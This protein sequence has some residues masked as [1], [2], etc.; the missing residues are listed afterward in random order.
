MLIKE[1]RVILPMTVEEYQ[2]AQLYSVAEAS[3]NET[4]GGEGVKVEKN[5]PYDNVPLLNG[6]FTK[7]QYTL[8]KYFL[9]SKVPKLISALAPSGSLEIQEEAWNAYP[10]CKTVL[11]NPNYMKENFVIKVE[12][13]HYADR[14]TSENI[15]EL[16]KDQ[17][18]RREVVVIDIAEPVPRNDYKINEDPT[19]YTSEKTGRGPLKNEPGKKWTH[20]VNPVMTCYKLVTCEFKW[21]GL[22]TKV[23][24]FIM[25]TEKRL[26]S[27]F[28]RQVFCWT[29]KWHGMT[30]EDIRAL[31]DQTKEE[32]EKK[33]AEGEVC[34][35]KPLSN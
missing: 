30:M 29:D 22:Q 9:A 18:K 24:S 11:S 28:H 27:N 3:K 33:R 14:G 21:F 13:Y 4:G 23:E 34:G 17:L 16:D 25:Q 31:E 12:T 15:H 19:K 8:K 2:V 10:Y 32:L 35:T 7:G 1:F 20:S 5:E 26:F 6:Q